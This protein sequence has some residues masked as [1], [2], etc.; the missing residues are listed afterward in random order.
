[1]HSKVSFGDSS[2]ADH[3]CLLALK[4]FLLIISYCTFYMA[5]LGHHAFFFAG[6]LL[7]GLRKG[8]MG[9]VSSAR[10]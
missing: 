3:W 4:H 8:Q 9:N 5:V 2:E 7:K 10:F 6:Y 1:M